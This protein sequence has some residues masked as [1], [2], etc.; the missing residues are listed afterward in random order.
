MAKEDKDEGAIGNDI[1]DQQGYVQPGGTLLGIIAELVIQP[2][3][4]KRRTLVEQQQKRHPELDG[5]VHP[6]PVPV[7][8]QHPVNSVERK[9]DDHQA[10]QEQEVGIKGC[11]RLQEKGIGNAEQ[12]TGYPDIDP[13]FSLL[14]RFNA[15]VIKQADNGKFKIN[16]NCIDRV[17]VVI[18]PR[19]IKG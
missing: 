6:E 18:Y 11:Q 10:F 16:R 3:R 12:Y 13:H 14:K 2:P 4:G 15:V 1:D 17:I 9:A 19:S 7:Y 5:A 8:E